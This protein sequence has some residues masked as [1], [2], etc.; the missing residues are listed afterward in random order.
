[1]KAH[2]ATSI[3]ANQSGARDAAS[4]VVQ[5]AWI[6]QAKW[7]YG[8][9][10]LGSALFFYL[11]LFHFPFV[12]IWHDG[13]QFIYL[14]HAERMLR[15]Q[16]LYR[17]L[18]QFNMPGTE[19]LYY[20]LFRCFGVRLWI[21]SL[22]LFLAGTAVS[23]MIYSLSRVVLSGA[24]AMLPAIAFLV[25]CQRSSLDASHHWFSTLFVLLAVNV[26]ATRRS[27]VWLGCAGALLGLAT[28]FTTARG[29][30]VAVG[31]S[32]FFIW[33]FRDW[34][35]ASKAILTLLLPFAGVVAPIVVYLATIAGPKELFASLIVFP[36]RYYSSGY[37]NSFSVFFDELQNIFPIRPNS[38]LLIILWLALNAAAPIVF[39]TFFA[40]CFRRRAPDLRNSSGEQVLVLYAFVGTFALLAVASAPSSPRLNCAVAFAYIIATAMLH[41]LDMRRLIGGA[42]AIACVA[43]A[44]EMAA[45]AVRPIYIFDGPRGSIAMLR[46]NDYEYISWLAH[47]ARPGDRLFGAPALNFVLALRSPSKL[48]WVEPDAITRPE[49]IQELLSALNR[50][51][52]RFVLFGDDPGDRADSG[53][54]LQPLR[55]YL[56]EHF[57]ILRS[58]DNGVEILINNAMAPLKTT[59]VSIF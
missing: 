28:I 25:I 19:Y 6:H 12:P 38:I 49:Q 18:F 40:K 41:E 20:F 46:S 37:A 33:K 42:L 55:D 34:R 54:N 23:L 51:P 50:F 21:G 26:V 30:A 35:K 45:A 22:A 24:A 58:F 31:V 4:G 29:A 53:D 1:M 47:I 59:R 9:L 11:H 2:A 39:V 15:G 16:I 13:D 3:S 32:L 52:T 17:D 43:G 14:D 36:L 5:R 7:P 48:W 44:A 10:G 8:L 27:P 56:K 57:H